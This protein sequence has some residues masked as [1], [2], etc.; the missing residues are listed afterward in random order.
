M[1]PKLGFLSV[2]T[3]KLSVFVGVSLLSLLSFPTFVWAEKPPVAVIAYQVTPITQTATLN[4][5]GRLQA[6][7]SVDLAATVTERIQSMSF[8]EGQSVKKGQLLIE[9]DAQEENAQL[10]EAKALAAEAQRQYQRVKDIENKGSVTQS[11]IDEKYRQWQTAQAQIKVIEARLADRRIIAPFDGQLG[12]SQFSVGALV[13]PGNKIVSLDD[14]SEMYLDLFVATRYL[15][16]LNIGL[17]ITLTAPA[18]PKQTFSGKIIAISPR[19]E[20]DLRL[21]KVRALIANPQQQLKTNMSVQARLQLSPQ[22]QLRVP[23]TALIMLGDQT[24]VYQLLADQNN[25]YKT[26]K[27][28]IK[29]GE[30]G[31]SSSE[32]VEGLKADS[33]VVSQGVLSLKPNK[34]VTIKAIE[35]GQSQEDLL[36]PKAKKSDA[37]P[38]KTAQP[39]PEAL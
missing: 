7:Q 24:F 26:K 16:Q 6:K 22:T 3:P 1:L 39:A 30:M 18:F 20:A 4:A 11:M 19:L 28:L 38:S 8:S 21:I 29:L 37:A 33:L 9:L 12:F 35:T 25:T 31:V 23:N 17:P 36:K 27:T 13:T 15:S 14:T 34:P 5:L 2:K 32:V 10:E